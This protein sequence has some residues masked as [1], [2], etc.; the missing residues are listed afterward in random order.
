MNQILNDQNRSL[1]Q[2]R[3]PGLD[4]FTRTRWATGVFAVMI[5]SFLLSHS[6][7]QAPPAKSKLQEK[8]AEKYSTGAL[9]PT[10]PQLEDLLRRAELF[11]QDGGFRNATL[12]WSKILS[13]GGSSLVTMDGETYLSLAAV[14]EQ[15]IAELPADGLAAYRITAD[16]EARALLAQSEE[17]GRQEI[18]HEV[19]DRYFLSSLG[20]QA[21]YE[22]AAIALDNLELVTATRLLEKIVEVH[23]DPDVDLGQVFLRLAVC[24]A[25][26]GQNTKSKQA[27]ETALRAT[28]PLPPT[29][30]E[31]VSRLMTAD[32]TFNKM[33]TSVTDA[34]WA[35]PY[36]NSRRDGVMPALP[37]DFLKSDL[38]VV[39]KTDLDLTMESNQIVNPYSSRSRS[40]TKFKKPTHEALLQ[41]W[42]KY[43]TLAANAL[44][45]PD[46]IVVKSARAPALWKTQPANSLVKQW[47]S[48]WFNNYRMDD[49]TVSRMLN[50]TMYGGLQG[51]TSYTPLELFLFKDRPHHS[52]AIIDGIVFA[53]EGQPYAKTAERPKRKSQNN[54]DFWGPQSL[55]R[56]RTNWLTAYD[57][58]S[59]KII[60]S[61][62]AAEPPESKSTGAVQEKASASVSVPAYLESL[63]EKYIVENGIGFIGP[64]VAAGDAI[65]IPVSQGGAI[66][67]YS[68]ETRTGRTF[69]KTQLCDEPSTSAS[70]HATA[71]L[72]VDGQ[73][74]YLC[75]GVG[76]VFSVN[77]ADGRIRFA[78]RY[79]RDLEGNK[80]PQQRMRGNQMP[81]TVR[82]RGWEDDLVVPFE[83]VLIVMASDS[84]QVMAFDRT[85]GDF[86]WAAPRS[87]FNAED[88]MN[89]CL[90]IRGPYLYAAGTS[91]LLAYD[92][93]GQGRLVWREDLNGR[94]IA[95]G[96]LTQNSILM[97]TADSITQFRFD[98]APSGRATR[99]YQ[100]GVKGL[101]GEPLGTLYSDG[102]QIWSLQPGRVL[103]LAR[104]TDQLDQLNQRIEQGDMDAV[105]LR[106]QLAME[107]NSMERNSSPSLNADW[108]TLV[109]N[110]HQLSRVTQSE[111]GSLRW[112]EKFSASGNS[113][114]PAIW[115]F[116]EILNQELQG[117]S[118]VDWK[119]VRENPAPLL[120]VLE[121]RKQLD[122][123]S[124]DVW[125]HFGL[126]AGVESW[127]VPWIRS[128]LT[129]E[130]GQSVASRWL[131]DAAPSVRILGLQLLKLPLDPNSM[132]EVVALARSAETGEA[133]EQ[134]RV[135][136]MLLLLRSRQTEGIE[137]AFSLLETERPAI[138]QKVFTALQNALGVNWIF[139]SLAAA[140]VRDRQIERMRQQ[141]LE[142][143]SQVSWKPIPEP[144]AVNFNRIIAGFPRSGQFI[145][146]SY[147]GEVLARHEFKGALE[148]MGCENGDLWVASSDR[149]TRLSPLKKIRFTVELTQRPVSLS[150]LNNDGVLVC[151]GEYPGK[152][153]AV[154]SLG[155]V[156]WDREL[157]QQALAAACKTEDQHLLVSSVVTG[158][159]ID[160][161]ATPN[162]KSP[163]Q[164]ISITDL[165]PLPNGNLLTTSSLN[166]E[167][168]EMNREGKTIFRKRGLPQAREAIRLSNGHTIVACSQGIIALN[169]DGNEVWSLRSEGA[170]TC[171]AAY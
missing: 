122:S 26:L 50:A 115:L 62:L 99:T 83:G 70:P 160:M 150:P 36:G 116:T 143:N 167:I 144:L 145:E 142:M 30:L 54:Q 92:L 9:V 86:V 140:E 87:P 134:C 102:Q 68:I 79:V 111:L 76:V 113:G 27:F 136:A 88:S 7:A 98:D 119:T 85:R 25:G 124:V 20:D 28:P 114:D 37:A 151:H 59:G 8:N 138:R 139:D 15:R 126:K 71:Y 22:F 91:S 75:C 29:L 127:L 171:V 11:A 104:A 60:W 132:P 58:K 109:Q 165:C 164:A 21:A 108:Q 121:Q 117:N 55:R 107:E 34:F 82:F 141:W 97:P 5:L 66:W 101:G 41:Q 118:W 135:A 4:E 149:L 40:V 120:K 12:L 43:E 13:E 39:G 2:P 169:R 170:A 125:R 129:P 48:L 130:A 84:N 154:D 61:R 95:R 155:N 32:E 156:S 52:M 94:A 63:N 78:R 105:W 137:P 166:G 67:L 147:E 46:G 35:M 73:D 90:G 6:R 23:P 77:V 146:L 47:E 152:I 42:E 103:A 162:R 163:F 123:D 96:C 159:L 80:N 18:L 133:A 153:W 10:S 14:V 74:A 72:S 56:A 45:T 69:W 128:R 31:Q 157:G 112:L 81:A 19:T 100:V 53:I 131:R 33:S 148:C 106:L 3:L 16:G 161:D 110:R 93:R 65:L 44:L 89:Y 24:Y 158:Q 49:Y 57:L 38:T 51:S 1:D 168:L 17:R 64:P